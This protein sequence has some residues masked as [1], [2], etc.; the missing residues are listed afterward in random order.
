MY[1]FA[2]WD[3]VW[4]P[5]VINDDIRQQVYWM[6]KWQD[7]DLYKDHYLT[8]YAQNYVPWG[9]QA[10]YKGASYFINPV[11]FSKILTAVLFVM[12]AGLLFVLAVS[13]GDELTGLLTVCV[14]FYFGFFLGAISGGLSR[15]FVFPLLILYLIFLARGKTVSGGCVLI[16]QALFNPYL[17]VL[18]LV[19]HGLFLLHSRW[20][21]YINRR[22]PEYCHDRFPSIPFLLEL[23]PVIIGIALIFFKYRI[24]QNKMFG[25]IVSKAEMVG[26]VEYTAAGRYEI[27]PVPSVFFEFIRPFLQNLPV[28]LMSI[29][30][31]VAGVVI[32]L[33]LIIM[34]WRTE[35]VIRRVKELKIF[36]Y[37]LVAS[38]LLYFLARLFLMDLFL[39]RRYLEYSFTVFYCVLAG[40]LI[41]S[42]V[43]VCKINRHV[44]TLSILLIILG[45]LRLHGVGLFDYR[46]QASLY[47]FFQTTP[48]DSYIAGHPDLMDNI[49]TF[50][51]RKVFVSYE[52]SHP[53]YGK[54]WSTVKPWTYDF[55]NA[56]YSENAYE[57]KQ[58]CRKYNIDY[59]VVRESDFTKTDRTEE[60]IYFEPFASHIKKL[61]EKRS[62]F[63]VL[64]EE[65]FTPVYRY[66]GIR[67][68]SPLE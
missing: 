20:R 64:D 13:L 57:L 1:L 26:H 12:T 33:S 27:I 52:L 44:V 19:T 10:V 25:T 58:F 18:C 32:F 53:W 55:F 40:L 23:L 3:G 45:A 61:L 63:A 8:E 68:L 41:R 38:V 29:I 46:A 5:Y 67:V 62:S 2:Q 39:P 59:F 9:I 54:Y 43:E 56:Y 35:V 34:G 47:H 60:A 15:G 65:T 24:F 16:L 14:F 28:G 22:H 50:S 11:Q 36:V 37:L 6:Q 42:A 48:K 30:A 21:L 17:F 31:F 51:K 4:S 49:M 7:P 66:N